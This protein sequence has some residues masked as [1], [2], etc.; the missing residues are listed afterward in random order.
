MTRSL[1]LIKLKKLE[2]KITFKGIRLSTNLV[3]VKTVEEQ[4]GKTQVI[5]E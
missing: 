5:S 1:K 4:E 2:S 3:S